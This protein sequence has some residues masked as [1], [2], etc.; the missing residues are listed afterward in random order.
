MTF[1]HD[2]KSNDQVSIWRDFLS[3]ENAEREAEGIEPGPIASKN[4]R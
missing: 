1:F 4:D 2:Q 3:G